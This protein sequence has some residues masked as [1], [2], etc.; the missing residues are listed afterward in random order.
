LAQQVLAPFAR[1]VAIGV[2]NGGSRLEVDL[3]VIM[4][5]R[6]TYTG[7]TLRSRSREEKAQVIARVNETLVP[8]WASG[9]LKVPLA[10]SFSLDDAAMAYDYFAQPGKLGKVTL[11]VD[12]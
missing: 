12:E 10:R 11:R 6:A 3:H 5:K 8:L 4:S 7:S 1:V 2:G 9:D